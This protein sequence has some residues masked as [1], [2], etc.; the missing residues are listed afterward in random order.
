MLKLE[1]IYTFL[2]RLSKREKLIFY[3]AIFFICLTLIDRAIVAPIFS[4][5]KSLHK[6]IREAEAGLKNSIGI[7]SRKDRILA[8]RNKY[9]YFSGNFASTDVEITSLLKE[10]ESLASKSSV[11]L[12][13]MKPASA[14]AQGALERFLINLNCE[15]QMEQLIE[16]MYNIENSEK[17]LMI[18]KYQISPKSRESSVA[19]CSMSIT[20]V[21]VP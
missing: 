13:D 20:R 2:A 4:R 14:K 7:L 3:G 11:Y 18:E 5:I 9:S 12:I 16:F 8:E 10:I 21:V 19:K 15:A 6:E 1:I 17:L